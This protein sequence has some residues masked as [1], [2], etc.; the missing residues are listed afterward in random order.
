MFDTAFTIIRLV[1]IGVSLG[2]LFAISGLIVEFLRHDRG[3]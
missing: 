1:S 2:I 3:E